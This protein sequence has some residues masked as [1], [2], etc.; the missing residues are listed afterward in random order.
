MAAKEAHSLRE[1]RKLRC[2]YCLLQVLCLC[3]FKTRKDTF[4]GKNQ[5][6]LKYTT[7]NTKRRL[8]SSH[9]TWK[10]LGEPRADKLIRKF[11][12]KQQMLLFCFG[13][14]RKLDLPE[15]GTDLKKYSS[16][17]FDLINF[18]LYRGWLRVCTQFLNSTLLTYRIC[19]AKEWDFLQAWWKY[20][21]THATVNP[22]VPT[23]LCYWRISRKEYIKPITV[24]KII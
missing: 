23:V 5:T 9:S 17:K 1:R 14:E 15:Q 16:G 6:L 4:T 19:Y 18:T 22:S 20:F 13:T 2:T 21:H 10:D 11:S 24:T 3:I 8:K 12:Y 7:E